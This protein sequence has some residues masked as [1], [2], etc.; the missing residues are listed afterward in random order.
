MSEFQC[1]QLHKQLYLFGVLTK[2]LDES[3]G[4]E[5]LIEKQNGT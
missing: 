5:H 2:Q 3:N 4:K 1:N